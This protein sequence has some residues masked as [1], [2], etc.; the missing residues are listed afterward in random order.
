MYACMY[1]HDDTQLR[2][3]VVRLRVCTYKEKSMQRVQCTQEAD[4]MRQ[5][6]VQHIVQN[7]GVEQI[8]RDRDGKRVALS[9]SLSF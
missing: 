1:C 8:T 3:G 4:D 5:H 9:L 7:G 2:R 6:T